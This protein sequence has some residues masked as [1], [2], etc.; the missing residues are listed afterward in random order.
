MAGRGRHRL[1]WPRSVVT[2]PQSGDQ[3]GT[4]DDRALRTELRRG[5]FVT[6]LRRHCPDPTYEGP[7]PQL[8]DPWDPAWPDGGRRTDDEEEARAWAAEY[9][10]RLGAGLAKLVKRGDRW[11]LELAALLAA[12]PPRAPDPSARNGDGS[13]RLLSADAAAER[14]SGGW[15]RDTEAP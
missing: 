9:A 5:S 6:D 7:R 2:R 12:Q 10:R 4:A 11:V 8:R 14:L 1:R 15:R 13:D 3:A